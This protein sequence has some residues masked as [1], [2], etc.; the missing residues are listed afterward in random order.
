MDGIKK[1][2]IAVDVTVT[3]VGLKAR[4]AESQERQ[5]RSTWPI[6][7]CIVLEKIYDARVDWTRFP[8]KEIS[9]TEGQLQG[10]NLPITWWG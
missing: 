8:F 3:F 6:S 4:L 7:A 10:E 1:W 9:S 5:D 2:A